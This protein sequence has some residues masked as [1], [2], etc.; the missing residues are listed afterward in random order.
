MRHKVL[1]NQPVHKHFNIIKSD[2]NLHMTNVSLQNI[3]QSANMYVINDA[4]MQS[5]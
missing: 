5:R 3:L 4:V 1:G 2:L